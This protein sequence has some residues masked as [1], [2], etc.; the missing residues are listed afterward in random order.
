MHSLYLKKIHKQLIA[1]AALRRDPG[2]GRGQGLRGGDT[3]FPPNTLLY[4]L[5]IFPMCVTDPFE[6]IKF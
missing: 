5:K 6:K 1:L 2:G 4:D 3:Y